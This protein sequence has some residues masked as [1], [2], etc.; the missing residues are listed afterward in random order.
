MLRAINFFNENFSKVSTPQDFA[1]DC[2]LIPSIFALC[3][4]L[5][6]IDVERRPDSSSP[7]DEDYTITYGLVS[8]RFEVLRDTGDLVVKKVN[9]SEYS[10]SWD[11]RVCLVD[12]LSKEV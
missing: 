11:N 7:H 12:K 5:K 9:R 3:R 2:T 1:R 8:R 6:F 10:I 4:M